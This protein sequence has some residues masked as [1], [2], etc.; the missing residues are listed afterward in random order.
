MVAL[1]VCDVSMRRCGR[2][3]V[4]RVSL[5]ADRGEMLALCGPEGSGTRT[6]LHL[7][8]GRL[9]PDAGRV[10]VDGVMSSPDRSARAAG[11]TRRLAFGPDEAAALLAEPDDGSILLLDGP[12]VGL[13]AGVAHSLLAACRRRADAG[14]AVVL[15]VDTPHQVAVH[16]TALALFVAGRLLSFG[17]PAIALV[18]ALQILSAGGYDLTLRA[19]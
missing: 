8:G 12:T 3:L 4:Q 19:G 16:A 7:L 10:L 5:Y 11:T 1:E 17:E 18:P 9:V 15:T 2:S 14:A 13:D 6:L